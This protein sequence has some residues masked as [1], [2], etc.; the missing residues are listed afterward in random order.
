MLVY[1]YFFNDNDEKLKDLQHSMY[2]YTI[3][4]IFTEIK[5]VYLDN[6]YAI[7]YFSDEEDKDKIRRIEGFDH[8]LVQKAHDK[9]AA[10]YR[11][12]TKEG[13]FEKELFETISNDDI[14]SLFDDT[15]FDTLFLDKIPLDYWYYAY[16]WYFFILETIR[17]NIHLVRELI[18]A[19]L[20]YRKP[21]Q[22][23]LA[24]E[25][26]NHAAEIVKDKNKEIPWK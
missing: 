5:N 18:L 21:S 2:S 14:K 12:K 11:Y 25:A 15:Y 9:I 26:A 3:S 24:W 22:K 1:S 20:K 8:R 6:P 10:V 7:L 23:E 16:K 13:D 19:T 17:N 4:T